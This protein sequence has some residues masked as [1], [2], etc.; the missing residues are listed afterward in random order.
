M[1]KAI[2]AA[3]LLSLLPWGIGNMAGGPVQAAA[4]VVCVDR[5]KFIE[6]LERSYSERRVSSGINFNGVM[7][8]V[9]AS[10]EGHFTILATRPDGVSCLIA[11]GSSWQEMPLLSAEIGI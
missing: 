5:V 6:R 1:K 11:S 8:E 3:V 10:P 9:F 2:A 7:V 4:N